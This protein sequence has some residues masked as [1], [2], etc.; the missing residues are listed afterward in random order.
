MSSIYDD[1]FIFYEEKILV[2]GAI[3]S[4]TQKFNYSLGFDLL[5]SV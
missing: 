3:D 2:I 1:T 4:K 5:H